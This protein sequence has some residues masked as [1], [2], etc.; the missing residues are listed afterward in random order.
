MLRFILFLCGFLISH[1]AHAQPANTR[2]VAAISA[3][4]DGDW[5]LGYAVAGPSDRLANDLITWLRLR[6]GEGV[7]SDY[8]YLTTQRPDWP[9]MDRL[10]EQGEASLT[11]DIDPALV[12]AWFDGQTPRTGHGAA[13]LATAF[14]AMGQK[15][16]ADAMLTDLWLTRTLDD[17]GH[18]LLLERFGD[19]L[20]PHHVARTD[21]M[22]W[23]WRT[24]DATRMVDVL[25]RD[26]AALAQARIG[27]IAKS[28]DVATTL[29]AVPAPLDGDVGLAYDRYSW[30]A[31]RGDRTEAIAILKTYSQSAEKLG[32]P[33]RWSGWR[34]VLARWEMREGRYQSAYDL[35]AN[36]F[37]T[38]GSSFADLEW[39]AGYVALRFLDNPTLALAHFTAARAAVDSPISVGRMA[40]WIGRTHDVLGDEPSAMTAYREAA[41]HQTSYYGLLASDKIGLALDP[42]LTGIADPVDWQAAPFMNEELTQAALT[43]L[44]GGERGPAV[45]FFAVLGKTLGPT[46]LS[47]L[48]A[49]LREID[50]AYY[51]VLLGKTAVARGILIPSIYFPLHDLADMDLPVPAELSLSIARRESEF[52]AGVGSP[53]GALG[54]MQ[55]MPATAEEVAGFLGEPY[56][57]SRLTGDWAYNAR[58]GSKYLAILVEQFGYS[59]VMIAAGYNAGPSRP[60]QWMDLRGDPRIGDADIID[61]I[62]HIPFRETRNYVMRV[63]ES[64]PIY[65]ARLTGKTGHVRFKDMLI[66]IKPLLRP[67]ARPLRNL[68]D[69]A[70]TNAPRVMPQS[71]QSFYSPRPVSR[72]RG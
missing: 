5:D 23:R 51:A 31:N 50:E 38:E 53:V 29:A 22:L 40:Y 32:E 57:R 7:F 17:E 34:R 67:Q 33:F 18:A 60:E 49:Y 48:G 24:S 68:D 10:R 59:P 71:G 47:R 16:L 41:N 63:A 26:Q 55:L 27:Y 6:E 30:L 39:V 42:K 21:A 37:L 25:D 69:D 12:V 70:A 46:D 56:S 45:L 54:L 44:A 28:D 20:A 11:D 58:L 35:A 13:A 15:P 43:L 3:V 65:Q 66:G 61:W 62:E 9:G 2:A 19:V 36:H 14:A 64:L 72:P 1:A 52:N 8:A 4:S